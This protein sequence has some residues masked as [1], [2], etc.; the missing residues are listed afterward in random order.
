MSKIPALSFLPEI[1]FIENDTLKDIKTRLIE[2]FEKR[3]QELTGEKVT[4]SEADPNRLI[5][6]A[7]ALELYQIEQSID[8]A[9]KMN[10]LTY[11]Y[12]GYL[13]HMGVLKNVV[14]NPSEYATVTM[15][16]VLSEAQTSVIGIPEKSRVVTGNNLYFYSTEYAEIPVGELY[17]DVPMI[18]ETKGECGNHFQVGEIVTMVDPI[19]YIDH[20]TNVTESSGGCET[21][22]DDSMTERIYLAPS[23]FAVAGPE[24]AYKY[25]AKTYSP[26][27]GDVKVI[28]TMEAVV[29]I[30]VIQTDGSMPSEEMIQG[31]LGI[32]SDRTIRPLTDMV[33][34]SAPEQESFTIDVAYWINRSDRNNAAAIKEKVEQAIDEYEKW[35]QIKIARDINPSFLISKMMAA[36]AKRVQVNHPV[37]KEVPEISIARLQG[38]KKVVYGGI[39]DD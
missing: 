28:G 13:D 8:K 6:Y 10:L 24:D 7:A 38:E 19:E 4:L 35:Q 11:A 30:R 12:G 17:V 9:G 22:S 2:N 25:W 37:Y 21:E 34:V 31:I 26:L 16:Y 29:D 3:Y 14:R 32:L 15:R 18:C 39:E 20:V 33:Q 23:E 27:V 36:G 5:L 1:S